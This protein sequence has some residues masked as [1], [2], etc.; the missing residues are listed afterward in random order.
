[1]GKSI[2]DYLD[3]NVTY[4]ECCRRY[5]NQKCESNKNQIVCP[6]CCDSL[7]RIYSLNKDAEQLTEKIRKKWYKTKRL[8]RARYSQLRFPIV[9]EHSSLH[10]LSRT[11][12]NNSIDDMSVKDKLEIDQISLDRSSTSAEDLSNIVYKNIL[13]NTP[14]DSFNNRHSTNNTSLCEIVDQSSKNGEK[15]RKPKHKIHVSSIL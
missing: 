13:T 5:L 14:F 15:K 11:P 3:K 8:N 2:H 1:M 7:Q 4:D 9:N 6:K 10:T 12:I